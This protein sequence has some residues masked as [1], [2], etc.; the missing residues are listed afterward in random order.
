MAASPVRTAINSGVTLDL[1]LLF[2]STPLLSSTFALD[3]LPYA[4]AK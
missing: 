4:A 2:T 3:S 1:S